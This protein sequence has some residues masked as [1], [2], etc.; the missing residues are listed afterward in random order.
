MA[1][2]IKIE[3]KET[4]NITTNKVSLNE[5]SLKVKKKKPKKIKVKIDLPDLD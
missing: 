4:V 2:L 3:T 5:V 1:D